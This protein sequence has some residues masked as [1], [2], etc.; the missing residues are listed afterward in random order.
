M[1]LVPRVI[2]FLPGHVH[3]LPLLLFRD[4][5]RLCGQGHFLGFKP[6]SHGGAQNLGDG[7]VVFRQ[8]GAPGCFAL[9]VGNNVSINLHVL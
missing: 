7:L 2:K 9:G 1:R 6:P 4:A 3:D 8:G 5:R